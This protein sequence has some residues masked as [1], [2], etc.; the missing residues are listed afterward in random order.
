MR[1]CLVI[2]IAKAFLLDHLILKL[3]VLNFSAVLLAT[4]LVLCSVRVVYALIAAAGFLLILLM[5]CTFRIVYDLITV[6]GFL[7]VLFARR[8]IG[9]VYNV[10]AIASF[11]LSALQKFEAASA[12]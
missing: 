11:L 3:L 5:L 6:A 2:H 1:G 8:S 10:I 4:F 12:A 9:F 7:L